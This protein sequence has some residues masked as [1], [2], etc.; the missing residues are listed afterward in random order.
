M[1]DFPFPQTLGK[2]RGINTVAADPNYGKIARPT[3]YEAQSLL[4]QAPDYVNNWLGNLFVANQVKDAES[5]SKAGKVGS[6]SSG[7]ATFADTFAASAS[8]FRTIADEMLAQGGYSVSQTSPGAKVP[9]RPAA[10]AK[11]DYQYPNRIDESLKNIV[12]SGQD[13]VSQ[14]K[15]LFNIGYERPVAQK[16]VQASS[17]GSVG[18]AGG[19]PFLLVIAYILWVA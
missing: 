9:G 12:A 16:A 3:Q 7:F 10:P 11:T 14:V 4:T 18:A 5:L 1:S 19:W 13:F 15:G 2:T 17:V 8:K 6:M